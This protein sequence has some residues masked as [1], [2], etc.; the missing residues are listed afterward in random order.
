MPDFA[1]LHGH[2]KTLD[3]LLRDQQ[4]GLASWCSFVAE[5]WKAIA[6]MW[7]PDPKRP[8]T[9][10]PPY[11]AEKPDVVPGTTTQNSET[12]CWQRDETD[13]TEGI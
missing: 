10:G 6:E 12:D 3:G 1:K 7:R 2:V 5:E 13:K 4:P 11:G 8:A 9:P